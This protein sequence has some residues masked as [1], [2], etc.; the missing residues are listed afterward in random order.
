MAYHYFVEGDTERKFVE[1]IKE[2]KYVYSGRIEKRNLLQKK[3]SDNIL[4]IYKKILL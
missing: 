3:I 1:V 4:K 2:S